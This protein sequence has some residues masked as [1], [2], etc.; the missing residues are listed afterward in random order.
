RGGSAGRED[1]RAGDGRRRQDACDAHAFLRCRWG[2][3]TT[4]QRAD[5][6]SVTGPAGGRRSASRGAGGFLAVEALLGGQPVKRVVPS[7]STES[8]STVHLLATLARI[9]RAGHAAENASNLFMSVSFGNL[10]HFRYP[11]SQ[12]ILSQASMLARPKEKAP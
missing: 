3:A 7:V 12:R 8:T 2:S 6:G 5:D 1:G 4:L 9:S 11:T 10:Y